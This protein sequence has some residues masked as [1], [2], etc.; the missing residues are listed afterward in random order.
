[1]IGGW[2]LFTKTLLTDLDPSEGEDRRR[3]TRCRPSSPYV[4]KGLAPVLLAQPSYL[5]GYVGVSTIF[6]K[7]VLKK[8][9]PAHI[10]MD[11]VRVTKDNLGDVGAP[12]QGS[13]ASPT[14]TRGVPRAGEVDGSDDRADWR[15]RFGGITKRFPGVR[16]ARGRQ[17]RRRAR[18]RATRCAAR[19]ARARARSERSSPASTRP[20]PGEML[21]RRAAGALRQPARR[22]R[23]RRRHGAPGARVLRQ[24]VGGREPLPRRAAAR[25]GFVDRGAMRRARASSARRDRRDASTC[26]ARSAR[27]RVAEQQMVQ[28]AAAVGGGARVIVFDEPTSSLVAARGGRALRADRTAARARRRRASTSRTAWPEIFR[29]C[30]T[31]HRAARRPARRHAADARRS[32]SATLVQMMIGRPLEEYFPRTCRR[33][34][35]GAAARRRAVGAGQVQ[36]RL[37]HAARRRGLGLAGLVGAGRS[38]IAQAL[39]GL[40]RRGDRARS[41]VARQAGRAS[42]DAGDAMAPGIGLVPEDRKR[43]GLVLSHERAAQHVARR[44]C[45]ALARC[46]LDPRRRERAL[47]RTLLRPAARAR[48]EPRRDRRPGLSGGNQQKI[49]L[50]KWLAARCA[51]L[52]LDEPTR[53]VDVGAKA[54]IHAL[55]RRA[56]GA[57]AR[58][59]CS[60]RASCPSCISAVDADPR[61]ARR[62]HGG[63][64][65]PRRRPGCPDAPDGRPRRRAKRARCF[66]TVIWRRDRSHSHGI[67]HE[68]GHQESGVFRKE[69]PGRLNIVSR[70]LKVFTRTPSA[71]TVR[72]VTDKRFKETKSGRDH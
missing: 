71:D 42:R 28:I 4:E 64:A 65:A 16:R 68:R 63:R 40:D 11:L 56:G 7:V 18:A 47:A 17:L 39:F 53:G 70:I 21:D 37:L 48:A 24:P 25:G 12:A 61:A 29:L 22:A 54:E 8:D 43:Q 57:R 46:R 5:W 23:R 59:C 35:R 51:I 14:S 26:D 9:V 62:P 2:A 15:S 60:S 72:P 19:T 32:T 31:D 30:D 27:S 41:R 1:M 6:D 45:A 38:E 50:A 66:G 67:L 10:P 49:V 55:H 58:R 34:R 33:R 44:S 3:W 20:T 36:R 52:I 69:F 13:G